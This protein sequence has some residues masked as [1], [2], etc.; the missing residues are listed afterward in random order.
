MSTQK[1]VLIFF[2]T[3]YKENG[4]NISQLI[5]VLNGWRCP[6]KLRREKQVQEREPIMWHGR[7]SERFREIAGGSFGIDTDILFWVKEWIRLRNLQTKLCFFDTPYEDVSQLVKLESQG[8]IDIN[9]YSQSLDQER[10]LVGGVC[11]FLVLMYKNT[12]PLTTNPV[13]GPDARCPKSFIYKNIQ[14]RLID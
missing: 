8:V 1:L 4:L 7:N 10:V 9:V 2:D 5:F 13:T 6:Y 11:L 12:I 14:T 3:W